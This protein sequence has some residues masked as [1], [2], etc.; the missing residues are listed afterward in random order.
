MCTLLHNQNNNT[1]HHQLKSYFNCPKALANK[2]LVGNLII[3]YTICFSISVLL[4]F[5]SFI[6]SCSIE[7]GGLSSK[8]NTIGIIGITIWRKTINIIPRACYKS[9]KLNHN[10]HATIS[11]TSKTIDISLQ[12]KNINVFCC[13]LSNTP[14]L[15]SKLTTYHSRWH[16]NETTYH[17]NQMKISK[18]K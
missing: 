5:L 3:I 10:L 4:N 14:T 13:L 8:D 15:I 16:R 12:W 1:T 6:V 2:T 18:H 17:W 11:L 9:M 7:V